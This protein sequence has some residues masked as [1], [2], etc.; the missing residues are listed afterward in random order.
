MSAID[1]FVDFAVTGLVEGIGLDSTL[2][3][4][5]RHLGDDYVDDAKKKRMRRDYGVVELG[6]N[7]YGQQWRCVGIGI[8]AHRLWWSTDSVPDK[9]SRKYGK[10]PR[11]I[12]FDELIYRLRTAGHEPVLVNEE[13]D[14]VKYSVPGTG[15]LMYIVSPVRADDP[16]G[17]PAG[18]LWSMHLSAGSEVWARS[19]DAKRPAR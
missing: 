2:D 10:F 11:V 19:S 12:K 15:V 16:G 17:L 8:Q 5:S 1:F 13:T 3:A 14:Y 6:F 7:R 9:L 4:W 18:A